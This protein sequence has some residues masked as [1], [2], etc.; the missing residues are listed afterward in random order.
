MD[1]NKVQAKMEEEEIDAAKILSQD[2]A[3]N[4][5]EEGWYITQPEVCYRADGWVASVDLLNGNH[6]AVESNYRNNLDLD[7]LLAMGFGNSALLQGNTELA[8]EAFRQGIKL[9][10]G[11]GERA[12][13]RH[14]LALVYA[15]QG[16]WEQSNDLFKESLELLDNPINGMMWLDNAIAQTDAES[17]LTMIQSWSEA[18]PTQSASRIAELRYWTMQSMAL[19]A[20]LNSLSAE[21][22]ASEENVE[23]P[24]VDNSTEESSEQSDTV[25][26]LTEKIDS[27]N[28][29]LEGAQKAFLEWMVNID[30]WKRNDPT[31][32]DSIKILGYTYAG[33][34]D[35]AGALLETVKEE[36]ATNVALS[37]AAAN[38][39]A[40]SG[41]TDKASAAL[42]QSTVLE[43]FLTGTALF[44]KQ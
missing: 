21:P 22:E 33:E 20:E 43:P 27:T 11:S 4:S 36:A 34:L 24:N 37:F 8:H 18:H 7:A 41:Q 1:I 14:A 40:M 35:K 3:I 29:S 26:E 30:S 25:A 17:A 28:A 6:E 10:N 12:E 38:Y 32:R 16:K 39:Y 13:L 19:T 15:D 44:L 5:V 31:E 23:D 9:E 2:A 42:A